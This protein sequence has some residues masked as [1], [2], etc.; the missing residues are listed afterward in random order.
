MRAGSGRPRRGRGQSSCVPTA[1]P[2]SRHGCD[3]PAAADRYG[4][5]RVDHR[6]A[7]RSG[8]AQPD[9]RRSGNRR[10]GGVPARDGP[11]HQSVYVRIWHYGCRLTPVAAAWLWRR[12]ASG[13]LIIGGAPVMRVLETRVSRSIVVSACG[14]SGLASSVCGVD[15]RS[16]PACLIGWF[17]LLSARRLDHGPSGSYRWL[18]TFRGRAPIMAGLDPGRNVAGGRG[19]PVFGGV[20]LVPNSWMPL[21]WLHQNTISPARLSPGSRC[22]PRSQYRPAPELWKYCWP[23]HGS[24]RVGAGRFTRRLARRRASLTSAKPSQVGPQV[25]PGRAS[26]ATVVASLLVVRAIHPACDQHTR[27]ISPGPFASGA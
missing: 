1:D 22:W 24:G 7:E 21:N 27:S 23:G 18:T 19:G 4:R 26:Q 9:R 15:R 20:S 13:F 3:D 6:R 17:R 11:A 5:L 16:R 10:A 8:L 12:S 14:G 2:R 25:L